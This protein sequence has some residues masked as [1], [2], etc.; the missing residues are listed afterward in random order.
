MISHN[1]YVYMDHLLALDSYT[2]PDPQLA[3]LLSL[4]VCSLLETQQWAQDLQ[5][6]PDKDFFSYIMQGLR[7]GFRI[8]LSPSS[9]P[10]QTSMLPTQKSS[11]NTLFEK[12]LL[13][14][15]GNFPT[16]AILQ[17]FRLVL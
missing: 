12:S 5:F 7:L 1:S 8:E 11:H 14:E 17:V 4:E 9:L 6:H 13:G 3:R 15:C 2:N 10:L 16:T